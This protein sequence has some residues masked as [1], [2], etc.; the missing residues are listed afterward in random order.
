MNTKKLISSA[1]ATLLLF[2]A[3]AL[4]SFLNG[5][6][7]A[8][9]QMG[10]KSNICGSWNNYCRVPSPSS[11][12]GTTSTTPSG[13]TQQQLQQQREQVMHEAND[14]A[15]EYFRSGDWANAIRYFQLALED[16]PDDPT[17]LDNLSLAR[18]RQSQARAE[19]KRRRQ[20][21]ARAEAKRRRQAQARVEAKRRSKALEEARAAKAHGDDMRNMSEGEARLEA[22]KVFE[23]KGTRVTGSTSVVDLRDLGRPV[24]IPAA[25]KIPTAL[26]NTPAIKRLQKERNLLVKQIKKLGT[27]LDL[28]RKK[29]ASGKG[30][31]GLL[32]VEEAKTKQEIIN[33][34]SKIAVADVKMKS[35][36]INLTREGTSTP[37]E[38]P[39]K[40]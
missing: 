22:R 40:Q 31:K 23:I 13:P 18:E 28:I 5:V 4:T 19:A 1:K 25:V 17:I 6:E 37:P 12:P 36:V 34:K 38:A 15:V 8:S 10:R 32:A 9:A 27:K 7:P 33:T 30:N 29:K 11:R 20:A 16:S 14:L 26:A 3:L 21:Q 24:D 35:F 39:E 2:F